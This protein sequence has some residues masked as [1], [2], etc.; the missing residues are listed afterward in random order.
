MLL[1]DSQL[2]QVE[3]R[4]LKSG[5][6]NDQLKIDLLDHI[7]CEIE[8][9][10]NGGV[11]FNQAVELTFKVYSPRHIRK[12]EY[13]V[14]IL[15]TNIMQKRTKI[16]GIIGLALT[17]IGSSMKM[18]HLAGSAITLTFGVAILGIGFFGSNVLDMIRNLDG[19]KGKIVQVIGG[20]GALFTL[21]GGL[22]KLLHLPGANVLLMT[23]P[24][25]LLIYF[26][27]STYLRT[28][29]TE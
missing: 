7:A 21:S 22:C 28:K 11:G 6:L 24:F 29:I 18:L 23:G 1:S 12:I 27:F 17:I 25:L 13:E 5:L 8:E 16:I 2:E 20:L 4:I 15:T 10:M 19:I 3:K 9:S 26:S 14:E